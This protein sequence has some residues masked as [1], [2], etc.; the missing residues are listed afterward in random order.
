MQ[1]LNLGI[2]AAIG[3][4]GVYYGAVLGEFFVMH[5]LL[6]VPLCFDEIA[7]PSADRSPCMHRSQSSVGAWL[8]IQ[9]GLTSPVRRLSVD[10]VGGASP[11]L[12]AAPCGAFACFRVLD[13]SICSHSISRSML[14]IPLIPILPSFPLLEWSGKDNSRLSRNWLAAVKTHC[15]GLCMRILDQTRLQAD[16]SD[17]IAHLTMPIASSPMYKHMIG[18][19]VCSSAMRLRA[20]DCAFHNI[21]QCLKNLA[22]F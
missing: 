20:A 16:L 22:A 7:V 10:R 8:S 15:T 12:A 11:T 21:P 14:L 13:R 19:Q 2:F 9:R 18:W 5:A 6:Q 1:A 3:H 17:V 4:I